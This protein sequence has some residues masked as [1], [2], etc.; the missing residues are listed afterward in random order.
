MRAP[1]LFCRPL[2]DLWIGVVMS[3]LLT[4]CAS[5]GDSVASRDSSTRQLMIASAGDKQKVP[6]PTPPPAPRSKP[7]GSSGQSSY[8]SDDDDDSNCLDNCFFGF[9]AVAESPT[10]PP[11]VVP[12]TAFASEAARWAVGA[13]AWLVAPAAVDSVELQDAPPEPGR[14]GTILGS[15]P[16]GAHV[17]VVET[18]AMASGFWTRVRPFDGIEPNGW[19]P[20]WVLSDVSAPTPAPTRPMRPDPR[21]G[22]RLLA[23]GGG[24]GPSDLNLEYSDGGV[25]L[26][27][28]Y[29]RVLKRQWVSGFGFGYRNFSG[30]PRSAYLLGNTLDDPQLSHLQTFE[31]GMRAGQRYGDR[32]GLRSDWMIGPTLAYVHESA[33]MDVYTVTGTDTL[34]FV[35][36]REDELGRWAGGGEFRANVGWML[37][38]GSEWGLHLG[39][40][41][42][43]WEGHAEHSLATD[44]VRGNIH[45]WDVSLSY[46]FFR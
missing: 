10:P 29:M 6:K 30:E 35:G 11:P 18:H 37:P 32:S 36:R 16:H 40:F 25:R 42:F 26:D 38:S 7:D 44:F 14:Q 1:Y 46:S 12:A 34:D 23:G 3:A 33:N 43:A 4:G 27:I 41:M 20:S 45:G 9:T 8:D 17:V 2:R 19:V 22:I 5:L 21:W 39:V 24:L 31:I 28:Q 15:L 13:S